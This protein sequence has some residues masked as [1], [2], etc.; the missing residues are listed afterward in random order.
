[1]FGRKKRLSRQDKA[2]RK[3]QASGVYSLGHGPHPYILEPETT[4]AIK[5]KKIYSFWSGVWY[6]AILSIML[7]WLPP[8][9]QM[10]AGYVGGRKAGSPKKGLVAAFVPMSILFLLFVLVNLGYMVEEVGWVFG[11][12]LAGAAY[13]A[14]NMPVVGPVAEFMIQYLQTF[15]DA[16]WGELPFISPYVLTVIFGY[17]GGILSLQHQRE[18]DAGE[19][20]HFVPLLPVQQSQPALEQQLPTQE[21]EVPLV[22]GKKPEGWDKK[23]PKW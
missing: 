23:R 14:T 7:F 22:M 2:T 13:L 6:V 8:F 9:G 12:P 18:V 20:S 15:V 5:K 11:L 1:M 16:L 4:E 10:I 19:H 17:V 21:K 3:L